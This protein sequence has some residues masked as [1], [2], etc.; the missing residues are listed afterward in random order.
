MAVNDDACEEQKG[1]TWQHH[2]TSVPAE[3]TVTERFCRARLGVAGDF[4]G[5]GL[6][7]AVPPLLSPKPDGRVLMLLGVTAAAVSSCRPVAPPGGPHSSMLATL[8]EAS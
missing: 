8:L 2:Q 1:Q 7:M 5:P 3:S 6:G 4:R